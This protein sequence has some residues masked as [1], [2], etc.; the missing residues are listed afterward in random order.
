MSDDINGERRRWL[1]T[2][3]MTAAGAGLSLLFPAEHR[4]MPA[5]PAARAVPVKN[6]LESLRSATTWINTP[7][8]T[9]ASL[10]GKVVLIDFCTYTCINWLRTLP[11][12]RAWANKYSAD[13]LVVIGVHS[14]EFEFEHDLANVRRAIKDMRIEFLIA[15]DNDF[16]VWRAFKDRYWPALYLVDA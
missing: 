6:P 8:L 5:M 7:P 13:G 4:A 1:G 3:A 12:V 16:A 11:S 10:R 15:V 2:A 9:A 14:P